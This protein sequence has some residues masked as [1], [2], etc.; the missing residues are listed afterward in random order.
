[1]REWFQKNRNVCRC[2]GYKPIVDAV[3]LASKL[4]RGEVAKEEVWPK[5]A[6]GETLLGSSMPRPSAV[7]KVLGTWDFGADLGLKL[8]EDTLHIKLVQAKVSHANILSIDT[9]EAERVPGVYK[10]IHV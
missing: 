3:M 10:V 2:T 6:D 5:L 4:I 7:E 8:P 1:M 9:T